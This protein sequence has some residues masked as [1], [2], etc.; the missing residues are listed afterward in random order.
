M[1]AGAAALARS[2][3]HALLS[4]PRRE[5]RERLCA[6]HPIDPSALDDSEY[7]GISLGLGALVD[8]LLWKTFRKTFHRDPRTGALRGWNVRL[9]QTGLASAPTPLLRLGQPR[10]FGHFRVCP[11]RDYR[12]PWPVHQGLLLDY[13]LGGNPRVDLTFSFLMRDPL[14]ALAPDDPTLL[15][16]WSFLQL[17]PLRLPTPS[18]FL[19]E[20]EGPLTYVAPTP[21]APTEP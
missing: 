4:A 14:V 18:F 3:T 11:A 1:S 12:L 16:G 13:G 9:A 2:S 20:R 10:T 17:G 7:R 6:G 15:F 8:A 21:R 19:L 5:L